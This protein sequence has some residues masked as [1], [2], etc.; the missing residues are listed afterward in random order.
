MAELE[1]RDGL[2]EVPDHVE[3]MLSGIDTHKMTYQEAI[4][5]GE[6]KLLSDHVY[7][8]QQDLLRSH[9]GGKEPR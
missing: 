2:R 7:K 9:F 4:R 1:F 8:A 3:A 6:Q 5:A